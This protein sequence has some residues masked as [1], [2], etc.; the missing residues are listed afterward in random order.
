MKKN[1]EIRNKLIKSFE[2]MLDFFGMEITSRQS[3]KISRS[4]NYKNRYANL[5]M[6]VIGYFKLSFTILFYYYF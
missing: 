2:L 4:K 1:Q 5:K 3:Y 6:Y